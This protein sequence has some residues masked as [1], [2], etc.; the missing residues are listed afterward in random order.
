MLEHHQAGIPRETPGGSSPL[1]S[2]SRILLRRSACGGP[3]TRYTFYAANMR[4]GFLYLCL[5]RAD[6]SRPTFYFYLLARMTMSRSPHARR[7]PRGAAPARHAPQVVVRAG[8]TYA[9]TACG[10]L[11]Q[12]P[13]DLEG[14]WVLAGPATVESTADRGP[15]GGGPL[16]SA[17]VAGELVTGEPFANEPALSKSADDKPSDS[18][19]SDRESGDSELGDRE[20][21]D[22]EPIHHESVDRDLPREQPPRNDS[23]NDPPVTRPGG[24]TTDEG[25]GGTIAQRRGNR[26]GNFVP[27]RGL[28]GSIRTGRGSQRTSAGKIRSARWKRPEHGSCRQFIGEMIDGLK[29]PSAGQLDRAFK[30][31]GYRLAVLD[32]KCREAA[33]LKKLL[34]QNAQGTQAGSSPSGKRAAREG[35]ACVSGAQNAR[36]AQA[37]LV[38]VPDIKTS[39]MDQANE[40]GPP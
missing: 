32:Q 28:A 19:S 4:C 25:S 20:P 6:L 33:R 37:D 11:V 14:E 16:T 8:K 27:D 7:Q 31:V 12:L 30:W 17:S 5:N 13:D 26:E 39:P 2:H 36:P 35:S 22:S 38:A 21:G 15:V 18:V 40:R 23:A 1:L 10:V 29:V 24:A 3:F 34:K 9:C